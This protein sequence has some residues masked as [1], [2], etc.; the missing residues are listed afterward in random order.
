MDILLE[1][2]VFDG[3]P[4]VCKVLTPPS[5]CSKVNKKRTG[6]LNSLLPMAIW[7]AT[8]GAQTTRYGSHEGQRWT[9]LL[10][11]LNMVKTLSF[12]VFVFA[13]VNCAISRFVSSICSSNA[14]CRAARSVL[15]AGGETFCRLVGGCRSFSLDGRD[16]IASEMNETARSCKTSTCT[17]SRYV[18]YRPTN[19]GG[20][21]T[22]RTAMN[23]WRNWL[24]HALSVMPAPA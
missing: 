24:R 2:Q 22:Y 9:N 3:C 11:S 5:P 14:F 15:S 1:A 13:R 23:F 10:R 18:G 12:S 16:L 21:R 7:Q 4:P 6:T 17:A 20:G 8:S 19:H